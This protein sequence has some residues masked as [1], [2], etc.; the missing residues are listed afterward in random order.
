MVYS[1][2]GQTSRAVVEDGGTWCRVGQDRLAE[3]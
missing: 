1:E 3:Q 2:P